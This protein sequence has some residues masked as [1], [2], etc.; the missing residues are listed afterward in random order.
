MAIVRT[1][2]RMCHGGCGLLV[3][4]E[5]GRVVRVRGDPESPVS[6][7]FT[8]GKASAIPEYVHHP[9]RLT[10]PM[11]REEKG[12]ELNRVSWDEALDTIVR[13]VREI[14]A[15]DGPLSLGMG[16]GTGRLFFMWPL[17]LLHSLGGV[18]W[19]EPG[20]QQCLFP[21]M[22]GAELTFGG[23]YHLPDYYGFGGV[24]PK[25]VVLWGV[26][27]TQ[28]NDNGN[29]SI[30]L[31]KAIEKGKG[32][33][34]VVDPRLTPVAERARLWLKIRPLTDAALAL[35]W[36]KVILE[37]KLYDSDFVRSHTNASFLVKSAD[38]G[39]LTE[40]DLKPG[41]SAQKFAVWDEASRAPGFAVTAGSPSLYGT[42]MIQGIRC[43]TVLELLKERVWEFTPQKAEEIT[44]IPAS[45][46]AESARLYASTRPAA[47]QWGQGIDYGINTVQTARAVSL[48]PSLTGNFDVPGGNIL[49]AKLSGILSSYEVD[50]GYDLVSKEAKE[51]TIGA[52]TYKLGSGPESVLP[53]AHIPSMMRAIITGK[54]YP[55]KAM[56][57]FGG[58]YLLSLADSKRLAF[59]AFRRL[60][61]LVVVDLFMT[62]L[63][64]MADV[65]LPAASWLESN[66]LCSWPAFAPCVTS[67]QNR[68]IEPQ[69]ESRQDEDICMEL[70]RRF[71]VEDKYFF[72][73]WKTID[74]FNEWSCRKAGYDWNE[75]RNSP[76][77]VGEKT[78]GDYSRV[79]SPT[80]KIEIYSTDLKRHGYDPLPF[81]AEPAESPVSTPSLAREFPF[82]LITG[83]R[84]PLYMH[85]E[86]RQVT[87]LRRLSPFPRVDLN[88]G[89]AKELG[90]KDGDWVW[91][92]T[93]R[94]R[95][96]EMARLVDWLHPMVVSAEHGWWYPEKPGPEHGVWDSNINVCTDAD[97]C[98]PIIGSS[99]MR[100]VLCRVYPAPE[101]GPEGIL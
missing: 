90:I 94:G 61:L 93:P 99:T 98:D 30:R 17:R 35:A 49:P 26:N 8:C 28:T 36:I 10:Y 33:L 88:S 84:N 18:N 42:H 52:Q 13:R 64:E 23:N 86:Y 96:R 80:G 71:G 67:F 5:N 41:G 82:T 44:W 32:D 4:V 24:Y 2:C 22:T 79:K 51:S 78:Y 85:T 54:P 76:G 15:A 58:N 65:I 14:Q 57:V 55:V 70:A 56:L 38:G 27:P 97:H 43:R 11:K 29:I 21:R 87:K 100:G 19:Y 47:I 75:V 72:G 31:L 60:E 69:G 95:V 50:A 83:A 1:V 16:Q 6:S 37:E 9:A 12:G 68:V 7:G 34:I 77:I 74:E 63:A 62:P 92:E 91:I 40:A 66:R 20:L 25:C 89:K 81:F 46:I 39:Y 53:S 48:L 101:G 3:E 59:E 45:K 73:P